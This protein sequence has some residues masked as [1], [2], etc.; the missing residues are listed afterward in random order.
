VKIVVG[1]GNPG[2]E[3]VATRH[4][5]GFMAVDTL[6]ERWG[7][8]AWREKFSALMAAHRG[9][10][11][12]LLVKPQTY[13]NLSGQ[14]VAAFVRFYKLTV[15]DVIVVYDDI[16]LP[17][18]RLRLRP[19]GGA[20]GHRGIE[21]LFDHLGSDAFARVRIGVGRPPEYMEA[22]DYVLSRFSSE[23]QPLMDEAIKRAA[24]AV[25]AILK[26][27]LAKAANEYNK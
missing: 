5:I 4:N 26:D 18:G 14:A 9:A 27:G 11:P 1:L 13:M 24:D 7:V 22:A 25:E 23:E 19:G 6:A 12:V 15:A 8:T 21:S 20:G 10:E 2:R 3:Y 17:A 16:D